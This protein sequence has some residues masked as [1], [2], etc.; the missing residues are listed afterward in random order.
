MDTENQIIEINNSNE[1]HIDDNSKLINENPTIQIVNK[2][3]NID[4]KSNFLNNSENIVLSIT[5]E[6]SIEN[7][8]NIK[9]NT[10]IKNLFDEMEDDY[11]K[12]RNFQE[13]ENSVSEESTLNSTIW[14]TF[15]KTENLENKIKSSNVLE[16]NVK[17][18][19]NSLLNRYVNNINFDMN[20]KLDEYKRIQIEITE[21]KSKINQKKQMIAEKLPILNQ[22]E[23]IELKRKRRRD[24]L[25]QREKLRNEVTSLEAYHK[26]LVEK[27]QNEK[28]KILLT[29]NQFVR[30]ENMISKIKEQISFIQE[31]NKKLSELVANEQL[32]KSYDLFHCVYPIQSK[33]QTGGV[34]KILDMSIYRGDV[35]LSGNDT[36]T[37][38]SYV[39]HALKIISYVYDL[40][41]LYPIAT[42]SSKTMISDRSNSQAVTNWYPLFSATAK[43]RQRY[44]RAVYLLLCNAKY[45]LSSLGGETSESQD[46]I[47]QL[48]NLQVHLLNKSMG[49]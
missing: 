34:R 11:N 23:E 27:T 21:L 14:D 45:V 32:R 42:I 17:G 44:H 35:L 3:I 12:E 2:T 39:A 7:S 31:Q 40:K 29:K 8:K 10:H 49:K 43:D 25:L 22:K 18:N 4:E 9:S 38:L 15:L 47:E 30:R 37:A 46:I 16:I 13:L 5:E 28:Q 20:E 24:A 19:R 48:Y 26:D 1:N 33:E 36:S 6:T 41:L